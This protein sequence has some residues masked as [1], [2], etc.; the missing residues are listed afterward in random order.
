MQYSHNLPT[1]DS[2]HEECLGNLGRGRTFR[3]TGAA[4]A[5]ANAIGAAAEVDGIGKLKQP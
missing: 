4:A 5:E 3:M 2:M 1:F